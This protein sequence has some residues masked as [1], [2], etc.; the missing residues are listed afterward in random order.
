MHYSQRPGSSI[1]FLSLSSHIRVN[2]KISADL[3]Q[4]PLSSIISLSIDGL[5]IS[6]VQFW[7][8]I[9]A[10]ILNK[11]DHLK[12][13]HSILKRFYQLFVTKK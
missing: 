9:K 3:K 10:L 13:W 2:K 11:Y 8:M 7:W 12:K 1:R 4:L 5:P 6:V